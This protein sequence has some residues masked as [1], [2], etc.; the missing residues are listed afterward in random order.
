MRGI[1]IV[2]GKEIIKTMLGIL[3]KILGEFKPKRAQARRAN[4]HQQRRNRFA[5]C[6]Q[7]VQPGLNQVRSRQR[8]V[9]AA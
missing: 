3:R 4:S 1:R 8:I 9:H 2:S 6:P 7:I 5:A